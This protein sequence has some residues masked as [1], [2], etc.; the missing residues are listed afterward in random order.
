MET[1][2]LISHTNK[3]SCSQTQIY[4]LSLEQLLASGSD[5]VKETIKKRIED[6]EAQW[7]SQ[8]STDI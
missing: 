1:V 8:T 7:I 4:V 3:Q 6:I 5:W 2:K